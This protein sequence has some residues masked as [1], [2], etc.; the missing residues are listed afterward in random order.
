MN[1]TVIPIS[2]QS[3][4]L[5][6]L[7]SKFPLAKFSPLAYYDK[8]LDCIRVVI[9]ECSVTEHRLTAVMTVLEDNYPDYGQQPYVGFV[10]KGVQH[11]F[12]SMNLPLDGVMRVTDLFHRIARTCPASWWTWFLPPMLPCCRCCRKPNWKL[13]SPRRHKAR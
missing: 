8:H 11:L 7:L 13:T 6:D 5:G 4:W 1:A 9:R 10:I 12:E 2:G 3:G